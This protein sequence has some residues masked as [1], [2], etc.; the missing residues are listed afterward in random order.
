MPEIEE[1]IRMWEMFRGG[2]IAELENI[3][4]EQ[5]DW[6]ADPGARS[7]RDLALHITGAGKGFA[8]ELLTAEPNFMRLRDPATRKE[9]EASLGELKTKAAMI[10]AIRQT[11][12]DSFARLR[13]DAERLNAATTKTASGAQSRFS[14]V[15]FAAAHEMYHRGQLATYA[16]SLGLVP[17]MTQ[18]F[19]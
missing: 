9:I 7:V 15:W 4:E 16:R 1:A 3:P 17:A 11:G 18:R 12:A 14:G 8:E 5:W 19:G 2:T 13:A 10:E 6:R